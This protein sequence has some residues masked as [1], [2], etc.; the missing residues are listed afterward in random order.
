MDIRVG[1]G[2]PLKIR[3]VRCQDQA[4]AHLHGCGHSVSVGEKFGPSLGGS[5][6]TSDKMCERTVR[7]P[8]DK[9]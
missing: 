8:K 4:T 5:E 2:Q 6:H 3:D 1:S 7:V 9:A